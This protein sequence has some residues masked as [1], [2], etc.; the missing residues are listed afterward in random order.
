MTTK[1]LCDLKFDFNEAD[2]TLGKKNNFGGLLD[3]AQPV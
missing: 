1:S 3:I 2:F